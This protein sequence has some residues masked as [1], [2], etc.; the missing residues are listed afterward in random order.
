MKERDNS[1]RP[2]SNNQTTNNHGAS[3]TFASGVWLQV[4]EKHAYGNKEMVKCC[5]WLLQAA[6]NVRRLTTAV[7]Y[8]HDASV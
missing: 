1:V 4:P 3:Y 5:P 8:L 2:G 7:H 6:H